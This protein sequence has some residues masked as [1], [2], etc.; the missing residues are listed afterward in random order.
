MLTLENAPIEILQKMEKQ[1]VRS[2]ARMDA[3]TTGR[4]LFERKQ[5]ADDTK[6]SLINIRQEINHRSTK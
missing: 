6:Q 3:D 2:I 5:L 1:Y 4:Y